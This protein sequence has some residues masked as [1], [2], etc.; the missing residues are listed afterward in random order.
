MIK[1]AYRLNYIKNSF[2][3]KQV[4]ISV[5]EYLTYTDVTVELRCIYK[6]KQTTLCGTLPHCHQISIFN[7]FYLGLPPKS[8]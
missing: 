6:Y 7:K 5:P 4:L 1:Y 3:Y 8:S 2:K